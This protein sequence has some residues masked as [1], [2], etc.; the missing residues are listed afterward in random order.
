MTSA[1]AGQQ[2]HSSVNT[3][4]ALYTARCGGLKAMPLQTFR[5]HLK[6]LFF[7]NC[8]TLS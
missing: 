6:K 3:G 1:G 2:L 5:S 8:H 4:K 7:S